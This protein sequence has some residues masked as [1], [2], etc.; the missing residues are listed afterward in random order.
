MVEAIN[1]IQATLNQA[2][3]GE[4]GGVISVALVHR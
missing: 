3:A 4:L 2:G 1:T